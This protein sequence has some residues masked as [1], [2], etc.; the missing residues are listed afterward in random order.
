M[1]N[2]DLKHS[3]HANLS[4]AIAILEA[5]PNAEPPANVRSE[6]VLVVAGGRGFRMMPFTKDVPKPLLPIAGTPMIEH[7]VANLV[8]Q[9]FVNF[10]V[11][12][13]H[14]VDQ[15]YQWAA[16]YQVKGTTITVVEEQ[17]PLGTAGA[18]SLLD[19]KS[20]DP[21]VVVN[22]DILTDL[23]YSKLVDRHT[24]SEAD[25]TIC[26]ARY[27]LEVPYGVV[28]TDCDFVVDIKEKP[29]TEFQVSIGSY[30]L[31][32]GLIARVD[33][34]ERID[35]PDL[36]QRELETGSKLRSDLTSAYWK[37]VGNKRTYQTLIETIGD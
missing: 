27:T 15:I 6:S 11:S 1:A 14:M 5:T 33:K 29:S 22:A 28:E 9:G 19:L 7:I 10:Y 35:M 18:L 23:D 2:T 16:D 4:E 36:L 30:V 25:A 8:R 31:S 12:A 37:D 17:S 34:G 32:S 24:L 13:H 20:N 26:T 21:L 3:N